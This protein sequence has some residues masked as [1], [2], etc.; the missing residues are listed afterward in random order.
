MLIDK[1]GETFARL[2]ERFHGVDFLFTR[3]GVVVAVGV[4]VLKLDVDVAISS[5]EG[6]FRVESDLVCPPGLSF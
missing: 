2:G 4:P 3:L 5:L 1:G 6:V